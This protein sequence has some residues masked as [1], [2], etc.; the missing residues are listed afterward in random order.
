MMAVVY[1]NDGKDWP[2]LLGELIET[3]NFLF[4]ILLLFGRAD[5]VCLYLSIGDI[6]N[7]D[8]LCKLKAMCVCV[9]VL[10]QPHKM[11]PFMLRVVTVANK[12]VLQFLSTES[13]RIPSNGA[14]NSICA[15]EYVCSSICSMMF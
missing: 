5:I 10:L 4:V 7:H 8:I 12:T 11:E 13:V 2:S 1:W 3:L 9:C 15:N 6:D 14:S